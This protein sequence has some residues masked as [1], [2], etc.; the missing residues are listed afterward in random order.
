MPK[1]E[2]ITTSP[3]LQALDRGEYLATAILTHEPE[4]TPK[5]A[6]FSQNHTPPVGEGEPE[7]NQPDWRAHQMVHHGTVTQANGKVYLSDRFFVDIRSDFRASVKE[8]QNRIKDSQSFYTD[9]GLAIEAAYGQEHL[10]VFGLDAPKAQTSMGIRGQLRGV[11][12][13]FA[14]PARVAL[15]PDPKLGFQAIDIASTH[16]GILK[17]LADFEAFINAQR[18]RKKTLQEAGYARNQAIKAH[19]LAIV[20]ISRIQEGLYRLAGFD[21]L[22]DGLR[23]FTRGRKSKGA[24]D[25]GPPPLPRENSI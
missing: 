13:K 23:A 22:A 14:D 2:N 9:L 4:V 17:F 20:N 12:E 18:A 10:Y 3:V 19:R 5:L 11:S 24:K 16:A 8:G 7:P 25:S 1:Q 6:E 15:L 21:G